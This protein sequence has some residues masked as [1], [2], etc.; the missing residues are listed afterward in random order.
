MYSEARRADGRAFWPVAPD[1][2]LVGH[3]A[4]RYLPTSHSVPS[5][6]LSSIGGGRA[7]SAGESACAVSARDVSTIA[8]QSFSAAWN[9]ARKVL[10]FDATST[11]I[12]VES[13]PFVDVGRVFARTST[14]PL[15]DLH[16]V[17]GVGL[18]GYRAAFRGRIRRHRLRQRGCCRVHGAQLSILGGDMQNENRLA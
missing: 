14:N 6:A 8:I 3:M 16:R 9:F 18:P 10:S 4:I 15:S 2:I 5:G 13:T 12:D 11:T 1:T 17:Y 7:W